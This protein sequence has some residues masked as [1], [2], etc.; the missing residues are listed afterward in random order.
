MTI[1][2]EQVAQ[3]RARGQAMLA[4]LSGKKALLQQR[5]KVQNQLDQAQ[6]E[7]QQTQTELKDTI[8]RAP[9][10]G[11][12]QRLSLRNV[13]EILSPGTRVAQIFE[14]DAPLVV[15]LSIEV[16][17]TSLIVSNPNC[18][19]ELG[20]F[21]VCLVDLNCFFCDIVGS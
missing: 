18:Q 2:V 13:G 16:A 10:S 17:S 7:L 3:E 11:T 21:W 12:I 14:S 8:V 15:D 6:E 5:I 9:V 20:C 1:A 19:V 4:R